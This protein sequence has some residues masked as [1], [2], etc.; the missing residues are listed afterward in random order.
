ME[1]ELEESIEED[2]LM[3]Y[4]EDDDS[5]EDDDDIDDDLSSISKSMSVIRSNNKTKRQKG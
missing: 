2:K 4:L 5:E 1:V 3:K